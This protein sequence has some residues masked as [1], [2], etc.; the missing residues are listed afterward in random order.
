MKDYTKIRNKNRNK[1]KP[2][3]FDQAKS[4]ATIFEKG[5]NFSPMSIVINGLIDV[6]DKFTVYSIHQDD[7][8]VSRDEMSFSIEDTTKSQEIILK[9]PEHLYFDDIIRCDFILSKR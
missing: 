5:K 3:T 6:R 9:S 7:D 4:M 2:N 1:S 8:G